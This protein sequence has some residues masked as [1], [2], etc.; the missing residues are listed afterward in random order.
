MPP[1]EY[2]WAIFKFYLSVMLSGGVWAIDSAFIGSVGVYKSIINYTK[3]DEKHTLQQMMQI[4][5]IK[6]HV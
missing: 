2:E 5:A 3:H 1:V 6:Q 4:R